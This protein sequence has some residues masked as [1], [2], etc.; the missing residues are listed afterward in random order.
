M[1][2][3]D[4]H[5]RAEEILDA[6]CDHMA[7]RGRVI[8]AALGVKNG[9]HVG[10]SPEWPL[11]VTIMDE[12]HTFFDDKQFTGT[13]S[14]IE[15]DRV[16]RLQSKAAQ[17]VKASGSV[18]MLTIF[19]TQKQTG[20]AIP[21]RIR[22]NCTVGM[23]FAVRTRDAAVAGLGEGIRDAPS[24][25]PTQLRERPTYIGVATASL[26]DSTDFIRLRFPHVPEAVSDERALLT[27][28]LRVDPDAVLAALTVPA[29][30]QP[31]ESEAAA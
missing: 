1:A 27:T 13:G 4:D 22:D 21:T 19:V 10:P 16:I 7:E 31:T 25:C 3:G 6:L 20:D 24:L 2:S 15:K 11:I 23:S 30:V 9:W 12:C 5:E 26:P 17:L 8:R 18:M 14:K 29:H 28:S